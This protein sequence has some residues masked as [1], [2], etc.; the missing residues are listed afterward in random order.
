MKRLIT[1]AELHA[2]GEESPTA[3]LLLPELC[4]L[5]G[6]AFPPALAIDNTR[7]D[8]LPDPFKGNLQ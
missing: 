8:A 7:R 4:A 6:I 5:A 1:A 2:M 3:Y